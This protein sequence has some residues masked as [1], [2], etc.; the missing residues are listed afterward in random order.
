[1]IKSTHRIVDRLDFLK[2]LETVLYADDTRRVFRE[3]DQ[4]HPMLVR[5]SW[6]FGDQWDTSSTEHGLTK[7][8]KTAVEA[9]GSAIL[10]L[11]PVTLESGK[12]G[13]V[14]MVFHRHI[15]ESNVT[16]HLIVELKRPGK[17]VMDNFSQ[18]INNATAIT[19]HPEVS[20]DRHKWDYW[21]VGTD[22]DDAIRSQRDDNHWYP[23]F[24]KDFGAYRLFIVMWEELLDQVESRLEWMRQELSVLSSDSVGLEYLKRSHSDYLPSAI[25]ECAASDEDE[26]R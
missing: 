3:I 17:L 11:E 21:L 5:E 16:L 15:R 24:V 26:M 10:S 12:R 18:V 22:M 25:L 9:S 20:G 7:V 14:D 19:N 13:R 8:V 2:G 1:M 4:L 23:G 6:I